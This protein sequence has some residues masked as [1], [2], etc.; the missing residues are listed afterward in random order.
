MFTTTLLSFSIIAMPHVVSVEKEA[1]IPDEVLRFGGVTVTMQQEDFGR[2]KIDDSVRVE[3]FPLGNEGDVDLMLNRFDVLTPE[4]EIVRGTMNINGELLQKP[5]PKPEI[6]FLQGTVQDDPKSRVFLAIGKHTTNGLIERNGSKYV[7]VKEKNGQ[8]TTVYNLSNVNPEE[9]NWVDFECQVEDA[10]A[11]VLEQK[12]RGVFRNGDSC[13][14]LKMAVETDSEFTSDLFEGNVAASSEYAVTVMAALSSIM[15]LD[16]G[17]GVQVSYLRLWD[18]PADPWNG[19]DTHSQLYE[20]RAFW[21]ANMSTTPRHLVHMLSARPLGGGVAW[22]GAVC[23][24]F[25]YAVSANLNGSFPVPLQ[26]HHQNNWDIFVVAHE[27]GHNCGS[28]HTHSYEPVIDNCGNDDCSDAE[29][30]TIMSYC[31]TCSGGMT[32]ISLNYHPRVQ[33]VMGHFLNEGISC[34]LEC[35]DTFVGACCLEDDACN[36]ITHD[37]CALLSGSF[38][39]TATA[40]DTSSCDPI[41]GAC[42]TGEGECEEL[43]LV[44][45]VSSEGS[46]IGTGTECSAG[47]CDASM[48]YA[49][50]LTDSCTD[51]TESDCETAGGFWSGYGSFCITGGCDPTENDFCNTAMPVSTGVWN[52]ST[53]GAVTDTIVFDN[54]DCSTEYLGGVHSDVWFSYTPCEDGQLLVSTCDIVNFDSDIIVYQGTCQSMV[55][56]ECNGDGLGCGGFTSEVVVPVI[57]NEQYLIRVGGFSA[58][59]Y[60]SGQLLIGGQNCSGD[61]PCFSDVNGDGKVDIADLLAIVDHWGENSV[62]HDVDESG[63]V[64]GS[65]LLLVIANWGDC[66]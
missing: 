22:R 18:N 29:N 2:V 44:D 39:G 57:E 10:I 19:S 55:Q 35:D 52:F 8:W 31:H 60:G 56:V 28:P 38:L 47:W 1:I 36:E 20:L 15:T 42:C 23:S 59:N 4:S 3:D 24:S 12:E 61:E 66:D 48:E 5:Y 11:P 26:D 46:Y 33:R 45:C 53:V 34:S 40:C 43:S 50:C 9:M 21:E 64:D 14:A 27:N 41:I 62:L 32:N 30:G 58:D 17:V 49:C 13:Q 37:E 51:M 16:V 65:D 6:V 63:V 7:L 25:G 54:E